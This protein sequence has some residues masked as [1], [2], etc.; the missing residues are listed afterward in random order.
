MRLSGHLSP[1]NGSHHPPSD[2]GPHTIHKLILGTH[3]SDEFPNFL[4]VAHAY[5]PRRAF[6]METDNS[7]IPKFLTLQLLLVQLVSIS[8]I[9]LLISVD[10][11]LWKPD[12]I[13][14]LESFGIVKS[15]NYIVPLAM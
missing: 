4:M 3:T 10:L 2:N 5:V 11:W 8:R 14:A 12:Y 6:E 7:N 1:S 13:V 15:P 9:V